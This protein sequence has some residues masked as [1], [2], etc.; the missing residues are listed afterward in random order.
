[1]NRR[2]ILALGLMSVAGYAQCADSKEQKSPK[3]LALDAVKAVWAAESPNTQI[4]RLKVFA[5]VTKG[6][7]GIDLMIF[8]VTRSFGVPMERIG[9]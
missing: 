6:S 3:N 9:A 7:K 5:D 8:W 4:E 1:M 2:I